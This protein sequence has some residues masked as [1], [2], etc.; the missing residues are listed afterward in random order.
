MA[1]ME[2]QEAEV[3]DKM[4]RIYLSGGGHW[5]YLNMSVELLQTI[6]ECGEQRKAGEQEREICYQS[7]CSFCAKG[8]SVESILRRNLDSLESDWKHR[9]VGSNGRHIFQACAASQLRK[10]ADRCIRFGE[11]AR[12]LLEHKASQPVA[13]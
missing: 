3:N 10:E 6:A 7:I 4:R 9:F 13:S 8:F 12:K 11:E 2:E 5:P 1:D